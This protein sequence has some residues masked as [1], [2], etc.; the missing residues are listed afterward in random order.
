MT[1]VTSSAEGRA[2]EAESAQ[3]VSPDHDE[4]SGHGTAGEGRTP[5]AP[6]SGEATARPEWPGVVCPAGWF[7]SAPGEAAPPGAG[8]EPARMDSGHQ[9]AARPEPAD[10]E[11]R[12]LDAAPGSDETAHDYDQA[13]TALPDAV[14]GPTAALRGWPG[15][16]GFVVPA[17]T[18]P[19]LHDPAHRSR[20]QLSH[21]V[22]QDSGIIWAPAMDEPQPEPGWNEYAPAF[23]P[24]QAPPAFTPRPAPPRGF[25]APPLGAPTMADAP[26][27]EAPALSTR[28]RL[29]EP[30]DPDELYRAWRGSVRQAARP[31]RGA[32]RRQDAVW[33][34]VRIGVPAAVIVTV[35]A[36]AV[37]ML[38][39]KT[40]EMLADRANQGN[41]GGRASGAAPLAGATFPGYPGRQGAVTVSSMASAGS[42]RLAVGSAD[43]HP[44]IWSRAADGMWTLVS[45]ASPAMYQR[46][47][48]ANLTSVAHGPAGWIAVGDVISGTAQQPVVATSADGVTWR[49]LDDT[50]V[51][52]G[53]HTYVMGV[54]ASQHGYVIVGKH[55]AGGRVFAAMWWSADLRNWVSGDNGGLDGRLTSSAAYAVAATTTGFIAVGSHG[56]CHAIWTSSDGRNWSVYDVPVP[57][58]ASSAVLRLVAVN[59]THAVAAGYA[60]TKAG[61]IPI[62]VVSADGGRHW[63][64]VVLAASGDIG[65]VTALTAAGGG[66]V[67]AGQAGPAGAEKTVTWQSPDGFGWS[68][69][70]P[71]PA[72]PAPATPAP[73]GPATVPPAAAAKGIRQ[74]TAL[75]VAGGT[76]TGTVSDAVPGAV[77]GAA[78]P[79]AAPSLVTIPAAP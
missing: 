20:W 26:A 10:P 71:A 4:A 32:R 18:V 57:A 77:T 66:F 56:T 63:H 31:R 13:H 27:F 79:G 72:T 45:A 33:Q 21:A 47:G 7:L 74:I 73:A 29:A 16:P 2:P 11:D 67:A 8:T 46:P 30:A 50:A 24:V 14:V 60:V 9:F 19:G 23:P 43:G 51:F 78:R 59:G 58:G 52:A 49:A 53:P 41:R 55:V 25:A 38:T 62:V 15:G 64:Q 61:D 40:S 76:V 48:V 1:D 17:G 36:G 5:A 44:A 22:W 37:M 65:T 6:D 69:A 3:K 12:E 34:V 54:T 35:G 42:T 39:G 28:S 70:T 68:A 75:T